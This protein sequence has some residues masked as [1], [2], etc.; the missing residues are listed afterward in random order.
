VL[1]VDEDRKRLLL[2][3][4]TKS[5]ADGLKIFDTKAK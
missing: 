2:S 5:E 3:T 4:K 1:V